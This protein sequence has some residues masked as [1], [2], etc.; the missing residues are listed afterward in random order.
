M[1]LS[2]IVQEKF[3]MFLNI[4]FIQENSQMFLKELKNKKTIQKMNIFKVNQRIP[5]K[6]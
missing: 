4:S 2:I 1:K 6:C 5:I 3:K